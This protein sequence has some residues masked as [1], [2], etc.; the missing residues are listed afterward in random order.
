MK[1]S[2]ELNW[3]R[4]PAWWVVV[5][6]LAVAFRSPA[7]MAQGR[8]SAEDLSA[9]QQSGVSAVGAVFSS[10]TVFSTMEIAGFGLAVWAFGTLLRC[11][12]PIE[13][14]KRGYT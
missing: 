4:R 5:A 8:R 11:R 3:I 6:I 2:R 13:Y 14:V 12:P 9:T 7:V 1:G 10:R